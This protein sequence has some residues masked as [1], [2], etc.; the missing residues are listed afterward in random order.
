[1][2]SFQ[3]IKFMRSAPRS[4]PPTR[5]LITNKNIGAARPT[6]RSNFIDMCTR[7]RANVQYSYREPSHF[8]NRYRVRGTNPAARKSCLINGLTLSTR[9]RNWPTNKHMQFIRLFTT[10]D[11]VHTNKLISTGTNWNQMSKGQSHVRLRERIRSLF[12][13]LHKQINTSYLNFL[14][15]EKSKALPLPRIINF[16]LS[17]CRVFGKR[18]VWIHFSVIYRLKCPDLLRIGDGNNGGSCPLKFVK[19]IYYSS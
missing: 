7:I 18:S 19:E 8:D 6:Y 4:L 12:R 3:D 5:C 16:M 15:F 11:L 13:M 1:M 17:K 14:N 2:A 10:R 9:E